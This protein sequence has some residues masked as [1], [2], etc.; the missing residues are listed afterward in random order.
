MK[1]VKD[2]QKMTSSQKELRTDK[3]ITSSKRNKGQ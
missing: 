1:T 3:K 2:T